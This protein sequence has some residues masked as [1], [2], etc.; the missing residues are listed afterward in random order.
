MILADVEFLHP[1][2]A[3]KQHEAAEDAHPQA[4]VANEKIPH[5]FTFFLNINGQIRIS[6]YMIWDIELLVSFIFN[7]D[8][9]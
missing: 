8:D 1:G 2:Q 6:F 3:L 5:I 9:R 4:K 7:A